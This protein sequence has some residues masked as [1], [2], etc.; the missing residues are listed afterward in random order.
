MARLLNSRP[1]FF[2]DTGHVA[3]TNQQM[4]DKGMSRYYAD[5]PL[6][7]LDQTNRL[8]QKELASH[9]VLQEAQLFHPYLENMCHLPAPNDIIQRVLQ[10]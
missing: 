2:F 4:L 1:T 7:Y 8:S 3:D 10:D 6:T 5:A 9:A